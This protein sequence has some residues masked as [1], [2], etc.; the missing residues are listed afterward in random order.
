VYTFSRGG[1]QL[2][3][4]SS[5]VSTMSM[6]QLNQQV[7][8]LTELQQ[9]FRHAGRI[10]KQ[11]QPER[12]GEEADK[13]YDPFSFKQQFMQD[14]AHKRSGGAAS[15]SGQHQVLDYLSMSLSLPLYYHP[16]SLFSQKFTKSVKDLLPSLNELK[17][18]LHQVASAEHWKENANNSIHVLRTLIKEQFAWSERYGSDFSQEFYQAQGAVTPLITGSGE[19]GS[20]SWKQQMI[21]VNTKDM[22]NIYKSRMKALQD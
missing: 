9:H 6:L 1:K 8:T 13:A 20:R 3:R 5:Y 7:I 21:I 4:K 16:H 15:A 22:I 19:A 12:A 18:Q 14:A 11:A 17:T 2:L 10:S